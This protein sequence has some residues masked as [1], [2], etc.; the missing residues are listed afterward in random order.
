MRPEIGRLMKYFYDDLE[1]HTSVNTRRAPVR[2]IE[3][4][5]FFVNHNHPEANVDDGCSKRNEFEAKYVVELAQYL[6][7]QGYKPQQITILVMYLGQR[8]CITRQIKQKSRLSEI[9]IMVLFMKR[10][11]QKTSSFSFFVIGHR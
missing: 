4:S 8:Q 6:I 3:S 7:K 1:D 2:G 5:M 10:A 9:Q 11:M